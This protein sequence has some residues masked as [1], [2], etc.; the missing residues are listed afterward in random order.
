M[1]DQ[2]FDRTPL[3]EIADEMCAVLSRLASFHQQLVE[4]QEEKEDALTEFNFD[5]IESIRE[6]E[7]GVLKCVAGDEEARYALATEI[8]E[9][10]GHKNPEDLK[11]EEFLH[12]LDEDQR[13]ALTDLR[14]RL[15]EVAQKLVAQNQRNENLVHHTLGHIDV[16][17]SHLTAS[18]F[19]AQ[20]YDAKGEDPGPGDGPHLVDRSG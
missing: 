10:V 2:T 8:G 18:E 13:A 20:G 14:T 1:Q 9:M 6:R 3:R 15:N 4:L 12:F 17:M 11:I 7:I 19:D 16:F 5:S